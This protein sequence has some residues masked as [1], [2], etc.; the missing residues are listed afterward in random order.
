MIVN[1]FMSEIVLYENKQKRREMQFESGVLMQTKLPSGVEQ[2]VSLSEN[3]NWPLDEK[4]TAA[5]CQLIE[6]QNSR[7]AFPM[8]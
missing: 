8:F 4:P 1:S 5:G 6:R 3:S 2:V 7:V